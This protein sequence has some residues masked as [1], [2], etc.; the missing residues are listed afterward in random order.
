MNHLS[1]LTDT[2]NRDEITAMKHLWG[3][4]LSNGMNMSHIHGLERH[5]SRNT[6]SLD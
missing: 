6:A 2:R 4:L 5:T 3:N 1:R